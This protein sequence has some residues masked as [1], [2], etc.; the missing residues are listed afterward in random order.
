MLI[1][2]SDLCSK[3]KINPKGIIHVGACQMEELDDYKSENIKNVIWIEGNPELVRFNLD[4]ANSEGHILI[5]GLIYDSDGL[6][7]D[8]NLTN[9][10]QS[11]SI[12]DFGKHSEYHPHVTVEK[13]IKLKTITLNS[14]LKK[15]HIELNNFDFLNLDIQGVE[16]RA[17]KGMGEYLDNIKYIYT[18]INSG[19]VYKNN[20]NIQEMDIFLENLGF[21]RVETKMTP[22]EWGDAFYIKD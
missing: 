10:I 14:L 17:L 1:K 22:F 11:S 15:N 6:E 19:E 8:F 5:E 16:L 3:Y 21:R 2:F 12:L 4:K 9:N 13:K 7:I 20:D 18:E